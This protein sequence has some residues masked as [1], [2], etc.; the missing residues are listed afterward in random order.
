MPAYVIGQLDI[1]DP[2]AYQAYLDGFLPSFERHGGELLATSRAATEVIEGSWSLPRTVIMRFPS[3]AHAKA[4]HSDPD[5]VELA[6]IRHRT[7]RTNLV[8]V[9]GIA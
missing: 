6:K 5:Y 3:V 7:A 2:D 1:H 9:D 4:W 8:V